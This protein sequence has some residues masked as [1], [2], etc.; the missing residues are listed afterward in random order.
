MLGDARLNEHKSVQSNHETVG[1]H[2]VRH[3]PHQQADLFSLKNRHGRIH[4]REEE[5]ETCC[6]QLRAKQAG[7]RGVG[8][9][10]RRASI[11]RPRIDRVGLP[12]PELRYDFGSAALGPLLL[13]NGIV[14]AGQSCLTA[15]ATWKFAVAS[16][17]PNA[18]SA[19]LPEED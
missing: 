4:V 17:L 7:C 13:G 1:L 6:R 12:F 5:F 19:R 3:T 9:R 2:R 16:D 11:F 8:G 15:V 14:G 10:T 18:M